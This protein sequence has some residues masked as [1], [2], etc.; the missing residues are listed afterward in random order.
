MQ[1]VLR[2][3]LLL[4][5]LTIH[6]ML[7]LLVR[8]Y[9]DIHILGPP[10]PLGFAIGRASRMPNYS[11]IPLHQVLHD[12]TATKVLGLELSQELAYLVESEIPEHESPPSSPALRHCECR[13][14]FF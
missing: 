4:G 10:V 14:Q 11:S 12:A 1:I 9:I 5:G 8:C 2:F 7:E 6:W 13:S 3:G